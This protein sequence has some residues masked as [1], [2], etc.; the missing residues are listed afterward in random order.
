[1]NIFFSSQ[2]LKS[3]FPPVCPQCFVFYRR[4]YL[5]AQV[6]S[7]LSLLFATIRPKDLIQG[8]QVCWELY[9][10]SISQLQQYQHRQKGEK[11]FYNLSLRRESDSLQPLGTKVDWTESWSPPAVP[12]WWP[13]E[14]LGT[15]WLL[16]ALLPSPWPLGKSPTSPSP[17]S[18]G[19]KINQNNL[20]FT[21]KLQAEA[22]SKGT[23]HSSWCFCSL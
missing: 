7:M 10:K 6:L 21:T 20:E 15:A 14:T 4:W 9:K 17:C 18:W 3:V 13:W 23:R 11:I 2:W 1:M 12:T 22:G 5:K 19:A 8:N 16:L